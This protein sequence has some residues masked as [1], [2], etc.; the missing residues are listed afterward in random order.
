MSASRAQAPEPGR[1]PV[2]ATLRTRGFAGNPGTVIATATIV[3][4]LAMSVVIL[5]DLPILVAVPALLLGIVSVLA[6]NAGDMVLHL[7]ETGIERT[8]T[9]MLAR[10]LPVKPRHQRFAFAD[11]RSFRRD[12]DRSRFRG[13]VSFLSIGLSK[14]PFRLLIQDMGG[15]I[16]LGPFAEAF[17]T[18]ATR[19]GV[20]RRPGFYQTVFARVLTATFVVLALVLCGFALLGRLSPTHLF[21]LLAVI[22][23]GTTYMLWRVWKSG[24]KRPGDREYGASP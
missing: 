10:Y 13:E 12:H 1:S 11:M 23:P 7:T 16:D 5:A 24:P 2:R 15:E 18:M 17:E 4:L 21:R 8:V 3:G 20:R 22:L 14:P 6:R 9:P 19:H